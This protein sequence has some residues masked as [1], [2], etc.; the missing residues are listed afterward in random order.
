MVLVSIGANANAI[1]LAKA[2]DIPSQVESQK[3][4]HQILKVA[5]K[6]KYRT[7][8][9]KL[10]NSTILGI[11]DPGPRDY[12]IIVNENGNKLNRNMIHLFKL[13]SAQIQT[14]KRRTPVCTETTMNTHHQAITYNSILSN[15]PTA[16]VTQPP[17][18]ISHD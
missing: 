12:Q 18:V 5:N 13:P 8:D 15:N 9:K 1:K 3:N 11:S 14:L 17:L 7:H 16:Y 4:L 6:I 2:I 10:A